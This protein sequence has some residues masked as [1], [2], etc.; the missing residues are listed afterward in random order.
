MSASPPTFPRNAPKTSYRGKAGQFPP[1]KPTLTKTL[2]FSWE[3]QPSLPKDK[4]SDEWTYK[5]V[6]VT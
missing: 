1:S 2:K 5:Q 4:T 6:R 3:E